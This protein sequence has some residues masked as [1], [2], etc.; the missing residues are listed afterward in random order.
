ML[1][2]TFDP[3]AETFDYTSRLPDLN[4]VSLYTHVL[5]I[6]RGNFDRRRE[7][8]EPFQSFAFNP[9]MYP[10]ILNP[11]LTDL[12]RESLAGMV[13]LWLAAGNHD[14]RVELIQTRSFGALTPTFDI[15]IIVLDNPR[16]ESW[17]DND[18]RE[19]KN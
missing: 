7:E 14:L 18:Q 9:F 11:Y 19:E 5:E 13:N 12:T 4:L 16:S 15:R 17:H 6:A 1:H 10:F 3:I 8:L 2:T